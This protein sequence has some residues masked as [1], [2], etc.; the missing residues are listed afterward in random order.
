MTN[1]ELNLIN[2]NV[3]VD[4]S[5]ANKFFS[6]KNMAFLAVFFIVVVLVGV[7]TSVFFLG[8]NFDT[9]DQLAKRALS[10]DK[11]PFLIGLIISMLFYWFWNSFGI[12]FNSRAYHIKANFW[13]WFVFGITNVFVTSITPFSLGTEPYRI[14]WLTRHGLSNRDALLVVSSTSVYWTLVQIIVTWPSFIIVSLHYQEI[15]L[16]EGGLVAY[17]FSFLGMMMDIAVF[18]IFFS[19]SYSRHVHVFLGQIFNKILKL[20]KKP[21]K[22]KDQL[23]EEYRLKSSFKKAYIAEMKRWKHVIVQLVGVTI[24][25]IINYFS[26]YFSIQ[27]LDTVIAKDYDVQT[28]FNIS[29]VAI[30]ANNFVPIPGGEG[31]IQIVLQ[32]FILAWDGG[33]TGNVDPD[34]F[35]GQLNTA[36]FVW[37]AFNFYLPTVLGLLFFPIILYKHYRYGRDWGGKSIK[38]RL[39][40]IL[41][42]NSEKNNPPQDLPKE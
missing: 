30:S 19:I 11:V 21:Y 3:S 23:Y 5:A 34:A 42:K 6:K 18:V 1:S 24:L 12:W 26:V 27:L 10:P 8:I 7:F 33:S 39:A 13:E 29:N 14:Y 16:F 31:T 41:A 38:K 37:R 36:I 28:I 32:R 2:P 40:E 22:T 35:L 25:A 4:T 9:V 15:V 20:L 17:W